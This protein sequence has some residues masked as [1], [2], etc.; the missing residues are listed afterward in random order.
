MLT[1]QY[2]NNHR[3]VRRGWSDFHHGAR[4]QRMALHTEAIAIEE[5]TYYQAQ[6][7]TSIALRLK[8]SFLREVYSRFHL[9]FISATKTYI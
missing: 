6:I 2:R 8:I 7:Y 1:F 9:I 4:F 3:S 5:K